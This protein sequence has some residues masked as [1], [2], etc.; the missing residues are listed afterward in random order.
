MKS[1]RKLAAGTKDGSLHTTGSAPALIRAD[2]VCLEYPLHN[3]LLARFGRGRKSLTKRF[4]AIRDITLQLLPGETLGIVGRNGSGKSTLS[5]V[6]AGVYQPDHGTVVR[7]GTVQLLTLG[8]G[9]HPDLTGRENVYVSAG[10]LGIGM[11]AARA[12][13]PDIQ[14]FAELGPFFDEPVRTYSSGMRGRLGFAVAT[15]IEP[16]ILIIDEI[17]ATGDRAFR[18][19]AMQRMQNFRDSARGVVFISHNPG[20]V[21]SLCSRVIWLDKGEIVMAGEASEVLKEYTKFS[22]NPAT[23]FTSSGGG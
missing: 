11:S 20:Q 5:Y 1:S 13:V 12:L 9:F 2:S 16:D 19:K 22:K 7:R 4:Q 17:M 6:L 21:R 8:P 10:L 15:A 18:D 23:Y 3:T 14:E